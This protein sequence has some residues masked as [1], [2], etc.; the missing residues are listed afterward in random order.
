MKGIMSFG[1]KGKLSQRFIGLFEVLEQIGEVSYML[2]LPPSLSGVH[3]VFHVS[4]LR[5]YYANRSYVLD[6]SIVQLDESLVYEDEPVATVDRQVRQLRSKN[7]SVVK[8]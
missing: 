7:I 6:Y 2:A 1:K 4:M 3:P 5:K 8:V